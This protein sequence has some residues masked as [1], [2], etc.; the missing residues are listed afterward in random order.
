MA[1]ETANDLIHTNAE[2]EKLKSD[3]QGLEKTPRETPSGQGPG[4]SG[5]DK[6]LF[7][8]WTSQEL[9]DYAEKLGIDV[10][11]HDLSQESGREKLI[12]SIESRDAT[13]AR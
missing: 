2:Y 4:R 11:S 10:S 6:Q 1:N 9:S 5:Y 7:A 8:E 3:G 13:Q 12:A